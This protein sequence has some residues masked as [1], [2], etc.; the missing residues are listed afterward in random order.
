MT[1]IAAS[2]WLFC[3]SYDHRSISS[4]FLSAKIKISN[5]GHI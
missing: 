5:V 2:F 4:F 1:M 3:Q